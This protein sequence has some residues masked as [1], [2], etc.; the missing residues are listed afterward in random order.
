MTRNLKARVGILA[1]AA[2]ALAPLLVVSSYAGAA[3]AESAAAE[4]RRTLPS[5]PTLNPGDRGSAVRTLQCALNDLGRQVAVDGYYG[6]QTQRAVAGIEA[7]F[8]GDAIH[9]GRITNAYWGM[10]YG[11]QLPDRLLEQG[12]RGHA[13]R[14]LQ[15]ALRGYGGDLTV[16][17]RFGPETKRELKDYLRNY[18]SPP[19]G[20]LDSGARYLVCWGA[21]G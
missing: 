14:V 10:L 12:D 11:C 8:E 4:C 3:P 16:D 7:Q 1:F 17:G 9:P 5:Y 13:V 19:S 21:F 6:P 15:R 18:G 20:R 2:L